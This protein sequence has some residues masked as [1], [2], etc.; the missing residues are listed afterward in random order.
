MMN[1]FKAVM[2]TQP[3]NG[4]NSHERRLYFGYK[5]PSKTPA[6]PVSQYDTFQ[7]RRQHQQQQQQQQPIII[8]GFIFDYCENTSLHGMKY[9]AQR[10]RHWYE[11]VLWSLLCTIAASGTMYL[12]AVSWQ[13]FANSPTMSVIESTN[14]PISNIPFPS[15]TL[16]DANR[17]HWKK[18][19]QFQERYLADASNETIKMFHIFLKSMALVEFGDFDLVGNYFENTSFVNTP[20]LATLNVS[21]LMLDV[22]PECSELMTVSQCWW[23]NDYHN[24]CDIFELQRT[25]YGYCYS[26]NSEVSEVS[27]GVR[28]W[29]DSSAYYLRPPKHS[30]DVNKDEEL[31]PRRTSSYGPW[32]GLRFTVTAT[33]DSPPDP[34]IQP[35][36]ILM[37]NNPYDYPENGRVISG[38]Q[39]VW[40][41]IN[42]QV[43]Y[44]VDR[45]RYL[46]VEERDCLYQDEGNIMDLGGYVFHNCITQCHLRY[47]IQ[48]CNCVPYFFYSYLGNATSCDVAGYLCLA[49]YNLVFNYHQPREANEFFSD[50]VEGMKCVCAPDCSFSQYTTAMS[51][52]R[53]AE[54]GGNEED[55]KNTIFMDIHFE[56]PAI[57]R[58]RTDIS[59]SWLDLL[60]AFGGIAGLC[61]GFSLLSGAELFYYLTFRLYWQYRLMHQKRS[62]PK[63]KYN[64]PRKKPSFGI[65]QHRN[66]IKS[67]SF[68]NL[69]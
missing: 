1:T 52:Y 54:G 13:R 46:S 62:T 12:S 47:T 51:M 53:I 41:N 25:E 5:E 20:E 61:L 28:K 56:N 17:V 3:V 57:V 38:G 26:F 27:S 60:V 16:C 42:A 6:Y 30:P 31:R 18:A 36:V 44:T 23:R 69:R 45:V 11:R 65:R 4:M 58:Y 67:L 22:M 9:I 66:S 32:G 7:T 14:F 21:Q 39:S 29:F 63:H 50:A 49:K 33:N 10:D 43:T 68:Q 55:I 24:C 19:M 8:R 15:V 37:V 48:Y 34:E 64:V 59:Y 40:V 35:G 2:W